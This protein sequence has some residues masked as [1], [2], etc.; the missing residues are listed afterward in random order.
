MFDKSNKT[1]IIAEIGNNHEGSFETAQ[2]MVRQAA[3]C[4]VDAVKFQTYKTEH[5]ISRSDS[6]RFDRMK[7]FELLP[8][9]FLSLSKQAQHLG[10]KFISTPFDLGSAALLVNMVDAYKIS[11][12]DN[13]FYPLLEKVAATGKSLILSTGLC[14]LEQVKKSI[15]FIE[16]VWEASNING[17]ICILHCVSSYPAPLEE[18]N[19]LAIKLFQKEFPCLV[20]YSDHALGIEASVLAVACGAVIIEKHFT[21]DKNYSDF[22]DHQLSADPAE[23]KELVTRIRFAEKMLGSEHKVLQKC[24]EEALPLLRRSIVADKV[25]PEG[26]IISIEDLT[27]TR[28]GNGLPPGQESLLEGKKLNKSM[29]IGN[30]IKLEDVD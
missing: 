15:N 1:F 5:Y 11:S 6:V 23:M 27:W 4:G 29:R 9:Q 20:G 24:E 16:D 3:A 26:H 12:S 7:S 14:D 19:L 17:Q 2:E 18:L 13:T 22:R 10:L 30:I 8:E 28:P 21:L 25:L